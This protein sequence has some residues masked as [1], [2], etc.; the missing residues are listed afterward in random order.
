MRRRPIQRP[1]ANKNKAIQCTDKLFPKMAGRSF[2]SQLER[3]VGQWLCAREMNGEISDL[4]F[5]ST[6]KLSRAKVAWRVDFSYIESGQLWYHEAKG[7]AI[8]PYPT[9]L[10]LYRIYGPAPLRISK[11]SAKRHFITETVYPEDWKKG[12]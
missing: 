2:G 9:K 7:R 3:S 6:V 11:G 4:K 1:K 10:K 8:E 5:Q 12:D